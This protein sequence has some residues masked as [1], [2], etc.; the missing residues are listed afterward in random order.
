EQLL[1]L[2]SEDYVVIDHRIVGWEPMRGRDGFAALTTSAW[3]AA[4][5]RIEVDEVL[6]SSDRAI[7]IR[8]KWT[9]HSQ[10]GG[11]E[12]VVEAGQVGVLDDQSRVV[13]VEQFETEDRA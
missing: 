1:E 10:D 11:G 13:L 5:I 2:V 3:A 4:E 7:A 6:A 8:M 12:F 9:G